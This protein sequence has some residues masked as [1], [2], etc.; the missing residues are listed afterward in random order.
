MSLYGINENIEMEED[1]EYQQQLS[2]FVN[3][4]TEKGI[5][6]V[7]V[8]EVIAGL[9]NRRSFLDVGAGGGDLTIP[10][11]QS[12]DETTIVEPN[13]RQAIYLKKRCPR[14]KIF[15]DSWEKVDLN[16][17]KYDF[18]L[19]SHVL[20]Y[21]VEGSWLTTIKKMYDHLE[22]GGRVAIVL[23]SPIG[24]VANFFNQF[25]HYDVN[26][27]ELWGN[28]I[29]RYGDDAVEVRYFLNE[30]WTES[31]EDMVNIGLFLLIDRRFREYKKKIR[32]FI[33]SHHKTTNGYRLIQDEVL[34]L[35]K[36]H[37]S[38]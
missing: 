20:Y 12:F 18:I 26:V 17:K 9:S 11:S 13:E 37:V 38:D 2:L 1:A 24:E 23:Q 15:N 10:I 16:L 4:S 33:E 28:L 29:R 34:I 3:S 22:D 25:A 7:K 32:H 36:K 5:E 21:I 14:Y 6:L 27:L 19:C 30:I 35:L 8:G 31:L